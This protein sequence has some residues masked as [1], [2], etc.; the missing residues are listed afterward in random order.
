M[1]GVI[2]KSMIYFI[3][4]DISKVEDV[5]RVVVFNTIEDVFK[6]EAV[7]KKSTTDKQFALFN[8][9][10]SGARYYFSNK[11]NINELKR[12]S[13]KYSNFGK[14]SDNPFLTIRSYKNQAR[15]IFGKQNLNKAFFGPEETNTLIINASDLIEYL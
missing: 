15:S 4:T 1:K 5:E 13:K 8:L 3:L 12:A 2:P 6:F 7:W 14:G 11:E 9:I 10:S